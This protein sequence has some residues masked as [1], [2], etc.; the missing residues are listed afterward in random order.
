MEPVR[1]VE[2]TDV[3]WRRMAAALLDVIGFLVVAALTFWLL[4]RPLA[5]LVA[6]ALAA[7]SWVLLQGRTGATPGKH[8]VG[9]RVVDA[10]GRPCGERA[11]LARTAL[12]VVDGFPY[13]LPLVGYTAAF[14]DRF[15]RRLGDRAART[16]VVDRRY[17]GHPP[18]TVA[19]PTAGGAPSLLGTR[20]AYRTDWTNPVVRTG[21]YAGVTDTTTANA[22]ETA[23]ITRPVGAA[24]ATVPGQVTLGP[25]LAL[26]AGAG[27][28]ATYDGEAGGFLR[29]DEVHGCWAVFDEDTRQWRTAGTTRPT[30][31]S[32]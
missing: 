3:L 14:G 5:T 17:V 23:D 28:G 29:W 25:P 18:F 31:V 20:A 6:I 7:G 10:D 21:G 13:V 22:P 9:L 19:V 26:P 2:P 15:G 30:A 12:W 8:V 24:P 16:Y 1:I 27:A 32:R 4:P 11:A